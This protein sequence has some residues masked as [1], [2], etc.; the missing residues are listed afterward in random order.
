MV[1]PEVISLQSM[2]VD[3]IFKVAIQTSL[4]CSPL[5]VSDGMPEDHPRDPNH[6]REKSPQCPELGV[7]CRNAGDVGAVFF[8][9]TSFKCCP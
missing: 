8:P 6:H 2:S 5:L 7:I 1:S 3:S 4:D 9:N